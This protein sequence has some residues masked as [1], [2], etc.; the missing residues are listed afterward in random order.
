MA[1]HTHASCLSYRQDYVNPDPTNKDPFGQPLLR[2]TFDWHANELR[3]MEYMNECCTEIGRALGGSR[4][5]GKNKGTHFSIVGYQST[6]NVGG[7][8]MG[9]DPSNSVVNKYPRSWDVSNLLVVGGSAFPQNPANG[10][11]ETI[12]MLACWAADAIKEN[13]VRNLGPLE[14]SRL[15]ASGHVDDRPWTN[16]GSN[17]SAQSLSHRPPVRRLFGS[18]HRPPSRPAACQ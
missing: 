3:M 1:I 15:R 17:A 18:R 2:M 4:I 12:G 6:H 9:S 5:G 11:T 13:D 16:G 7:A 10:P 8:V 14:A